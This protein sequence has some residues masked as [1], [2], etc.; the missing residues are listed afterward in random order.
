M[1]Q[2]IPNSFSLYVNGEQ[3]AGAS[4]ATCQDMV[5]MINNLV[6]TP[7]WTS[8]E[9]SPDGLGSSDIDRLIAC[10]TSPE[11]PDTGLQYLRLVDWANMPDET[12]PTLNSL[13]R[14]FAKSYNLNALYME[15]N[16]LPLAIQ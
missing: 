14:L 8:L 4:P 5:T 16:T 7:E 12:D 2:T 3:Y 13:N 9:I 1:S 6:S 11:I 10:V 15:D